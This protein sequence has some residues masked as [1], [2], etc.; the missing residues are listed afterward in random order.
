MTR[1]IEQKSSSKQRMVI[2]VE[3]G[4]DKGNVTIQEQQ[5]GRF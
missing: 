1:I 2:K 3:C 5:P 4:Q